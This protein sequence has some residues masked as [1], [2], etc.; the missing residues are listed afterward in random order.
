MLVVRATSIR[1][2]SIFSFSLFK[3]GIFENGGGL[4]NKQVHLT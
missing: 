1:I 3:G 2:S 4:D